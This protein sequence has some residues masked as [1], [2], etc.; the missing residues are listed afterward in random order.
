MHVRKITTLPYNCKDGRVLYV[1]L[2]NFILYMQQFYGLWYYFSIE[3]MLQGGSLLIAASLLSQ[4]ARFLLIQQ[5]IIFLLL[6][7]YRSFNTC[8]D[9]LDTSRGKITISEGQLATI[10]LNYLLTI[11]Y[12]L[13]LHARTQKM[14]STI[15]L[16]IT[17]SL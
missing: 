11:T 3:M 7:L 4:F 8:T 10:V 14:Q 1:F 2:G 12:I 6:L 9:T 15:L 13:F 17:S 16:L 5:F